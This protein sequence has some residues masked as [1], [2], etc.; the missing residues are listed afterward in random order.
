MA[1]WHRSP[2][3]SAFGAV[4][5]GR[6]C[7]IGGP[8][9]PM[10]KS[11]ILD[12][13]DQGTPTLV[14]ARGRKKFKIALVC[15][16]SAKLVEAARRANRTTMATFHHSIMPQHMMDAIHVLQHSPTDATTTEIVNRMGIVNPPMLS[17][18]QFTEMMH[19][20]YWEMM[21]CDTELRKRCQLTTATYQCFGW[22]LTS[23]LSGK[24]RS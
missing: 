19:A 22:I 2:K 1:L 4:N 15:V 11:E 7:D 12:Y 10:D 20:W 8:L 13:D 24:R 6:T 21:T 16:S 9:P 5:D 14:V 23:K 3:T 18:T 17:T